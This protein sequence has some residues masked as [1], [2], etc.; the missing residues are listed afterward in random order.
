MLLL[1]MP[2]YSDNMVEDDTGTLP[3]VVNTF[4]IMGAKIVKN[5]ID[6]HIKYAFLFK[7]LLF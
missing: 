5:S 6:K 7:I 2:G 1:L 4:L 3:S